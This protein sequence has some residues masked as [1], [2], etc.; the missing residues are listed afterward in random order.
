MSEVEVDV[1]HLISLV[2]E[3][4]LLSDKTSDMCKDR[5]MTNQGGRN[6][7]ELKNDF[8]GISN[9]V[10]CDVHYKNVFCKNVV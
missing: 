7:F 1:E 10:C 5:N 3:R 4:P 6:S 8:K 9:A 2:E